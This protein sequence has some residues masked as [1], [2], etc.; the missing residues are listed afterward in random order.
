MIEWEHVLPTSKMG[1]HL[2]CWSSERNK[3]PQCV[4]SNGKLKSGREC[5]QKVN[6]DF[7][8]AHNDL[9]NLTPAIGEVN[10]DRSNLTYQI[11]SGEKRS[12]GQCDF[13]YD[14]VNKLVEP[15]EV[16]RGDIAR[17][18]LYLFD[19]YGEVLGFEF[20]ESKRDMLEEWTENDPVSEWEIERNKR[21]C[22]EQG[23]GNNLVAI[24][25]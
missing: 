25:N 5:C 24:C 16:I 13:E 11:I 4:K 21:I 8:N 2:A 18:Q 23:S 14:A 19:K 10:A 20:S 6:R 7:R 1:S 15:S 17:I 3:F 22:I 12:Y 9:V